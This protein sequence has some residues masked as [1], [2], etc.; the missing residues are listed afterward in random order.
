MFLRLAN[1][2]QHFI[3][4]FS[5]ITTLLTSILKRIE[6]FKILVSIANEADNN[7][8]IGDNSSLELN[9]VKSKLKNSINLSNFQNVEINIKAMRFLIFKLWITFIQLR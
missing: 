9:L 6:L 2:Y 3:W 5:K 4:S 7:K 8:I 1:F